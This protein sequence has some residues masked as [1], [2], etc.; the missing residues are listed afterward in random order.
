MMDFEAVRP[1]L[2]AEVPEVLGRLMD[3]PQLVRVIERVKLPTLSR[4][5][6]PLSGFLVKLMLRRN[7]RNIRTVAEVQELVAGFMKNTVR[8]STDGFTFEGIERIPADMAPLFISNHRDIA[9]D[10]AFVNYALYLSGRSVCEIAIG[11]NLLSNPLVSDLMRLNRS[12][13]VKRSVE[14]IKAKLLALT[15]LSHYI[16]LTLSR[17]QPVWIAQREGRAKTGIDRTDPAIIKMLTIAGKKQ[18]LAFADSV[19][20]LN[21]VPVTI[22]YEYDPCDDLKAEELRA[23]ESGAYTKQEGEDV[24]SMVRGISQPKGRVH[25]C[26]GEVLREDYANPNEVADAIDRQVISNYRLYP[27]N[28]LSFEKMIQNSQN[29]GEFSE[30]QLQ[31]LNA[32]CQQLI[33]SFTQSSPE[34]FQKKRAEFFHRIAAYPDNIQPYVLQMYAN[35]FISQQTYSQPG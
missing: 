4:W 33:D 15:Q 1:Y 13:V 12:F 3:D 22:S 26:F 6:P 11:D 8:R 27:S 28:L 35:A 16:S 20:Q 32:R 31:G 25:V 10:P 34:A 18:G 2:D 14:G 23:S 9:M 5:L 19:R 21:I 30:E 17:Q 7:L 24:A 29:I